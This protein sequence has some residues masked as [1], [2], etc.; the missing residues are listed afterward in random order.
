MTLL[1]GLLYSQEYPKDFISP[2][3]IPVSLSANYAEL[4]KNHFH[5]GLDMRT[6]Q[7]TGLKVVAPQEGYVSRI[8]ISAYGYGKAIYIEH[9]NGYT[10]VYGHLSSLA[11]DIEERARKEQYKN[12]SYSVDFKLKP[13][14][15]P[16]KQ[17]DLV[18]LS[19]NTGGSGGPHLHFEVRDTK[20][21][22]VLNPFLFG[23]DIPDNVKPQVNGVWIYP[24]SGTVNGSSGKVAVAENGTYNVS[25]EMGFGVKAYDRQ[26]ASNNLNGI[27]SIKTY[28]N[29][30]LISDFRADKHAFDETRFINASTDYSE[31]AKNS[32]IYRTY[33][34]PGNTLQMY[35]KEVNR[36]IV[37]TESGEIYQVKIEVGDYAGNKTVR[38]FTMKGQGGYSEKQETKGENYIDLTQSFSFSQDGISVKFEKGSFYENFN[39]N[40]RK[41]G[42]NQ[43]QIHNSSVPVHKRYEMTITPD[44]SQLDK[45]KA[46]Q[47]A[48]VRQSNFGPAKKE[49]LD[50][51]YKNGVYSANPRDLGLFSLVL[52]ESLP[53]ISCPAFAK[54]RNVGKRLSFIIKDTGSGINTYDVYIDGKWILAEYEYKQNSLFIP[55][56]TKEGIEKGSHQVEVVVTDKVNNKQTYT[57]NFEKL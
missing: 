6:Q 11:G 30:E 23:F 38:S 56:L 50:T 32:W 26:N 46:S 21:E 20:T 39:L 28:V 53:T 35:E 47:Y 2:L 22:E 44:W 48:I 57:S 40:Y 54:T 42:S 27:Y 51:T 55:D 52:D 31:Q 45:S 25:G 33:L 3:Q 41:A 14:E 8:N 4:R 1:S 34:L 10:T 5:A 37:K 24:V 19:G 15:L 17:G 16:V 12:K 7:R 29:G 49:Y 9:P 13:N 18:A 36:G 43:Y